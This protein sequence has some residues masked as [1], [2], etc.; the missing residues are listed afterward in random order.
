MDKNYIFEDFARRNPFVKD[1]LDV[2][3]TENGIIVV[4]TR[5]LGV[6]EY[7]F[8][9]KTTLRKKN[10][11]ELEQ[12][13]KGYTEKSWRAEF[14]RRLLHKIEESQMS[15]YELADISGISHKQLYNYING[16]VTPSGYRVSQLEQVLNC[17]P[18]YLLSF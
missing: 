5:D 7:D 18:G 8:F 4:Q 11:A 14:G 1:V 2:T 16:H 3:E 17:R 13:H 10:L 12:Y 15:V 9:G 6:Y